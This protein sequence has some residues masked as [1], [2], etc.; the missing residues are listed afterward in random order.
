M[1]NANGPAKL[2]NV[3]RTTYTSNRF[4]S[5]LLGLNHPLILHT[6]FFPSTSLP[7]ISNK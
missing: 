2:N 6:L 7:P 5:L 3:K 4:H 1:S